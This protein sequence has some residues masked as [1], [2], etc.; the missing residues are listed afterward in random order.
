MPT[1]HYTLCTNLELHM[2][3]FIYLGRW[4]DGKDKVFLEQRDIAVVTYLRRRVTDVC[5]WPVGTSEAVK[6][7]YAQVACVHGI[8][9]STDGGVR[10]QL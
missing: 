6:C 3:I 5:L 2:L 8:K 10:V 9:Q 4:T 1:L 7:I